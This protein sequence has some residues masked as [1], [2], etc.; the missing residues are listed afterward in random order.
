MIDN[1]EIFPWNDN[2]ETGITEIDDQHKRLVNLLNSLVSHLAF[3]AEAPELNSVF[4]Q[5][6]DYTLVHFRDEEAIWEAEFAG[7]PWFDGHKHTHSSFIEEVLRLKAEENVKPLDDV[8]SDIVGVLTH[9]LALHIL[10]SDK[11]LAKVVLARRSGIALEE[12]KQLANEEMAG[13]NKAMINTIMSMYDKLANRTVQMTREMNRRKVAERQLQEAY[14]ALNAAK[15]EA[16]AANEAKSIYLANMSHEIRTPINAISGMVQMLQREGVSLKQAD[17]LQNIEDATQHLLSVINDI[18]DLSK[19]EAGKLSLEEGKLD[20]NNLLLSIVSMQE[21]LVTSKGLAIN[22]DSPQ[23]NYQLLGDQ[24]RIKQALLNFTNNAVKFTETGSV[25]LRVKPIEENNE[26]VLLRFE[27]QDTGIGLAP[28]ELSR[29]FANFEQANSA[30]ARKYGGTGLGLA[31]TRKLSALMGGESGAE[32]EL[33][34]GSTFWFTARLKKDL[35]A[36]LAASDSQS[37][38]DEIFIKRNY[39]G[40]RVL[41]VEDNPINREIVEDL[42]SY[43]GLT[44]DL[45]VDGLEAIELVERNE[46]SIIFMDM[47]MPRMDGLEATRRIR[48]LPKCHQTPIL[49]MTA[50]VYSDDKAKCLEAGMNDFVDKPINP[51][52]LYSVI[53]KWLAKNH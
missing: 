33:G 53:S 27:V 18:L 52:V 45:A 1:V 10:D 16:V 29:V 49:A 51:D 3:Q 26:D 47:F 11:R 42:L 48:Q 28:E 7:D 5:L 46:Y 38:F 14:A 21:S 6:K 36:S 2:F 25:S 20:I 44:V 24:T 13:A 41:L 39:S 40:Q 23:T 12:A 9:W 22:I 8:I 4:E 19:I 15:E 31:I 50:N 32:S 17:R 35:V 37:E 30:T 34:K 43:A